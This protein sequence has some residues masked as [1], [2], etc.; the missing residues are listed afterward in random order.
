ML[1]Q[2]SSPLTRGKLGLDR[3][4]RNQR[5]LI[6][7][8]AGKTRGTGESRPSEGAHPR[9]RGENI[10]ADPIGAV[11]NGSSP[12]TRGKLDHASR[13]GRGQGL[14][15]A[16]AGKTTGKPDLGPGS[17]AHPRSRGE[18][19]MTRFK[20][21]DRHGSSP[22]TRGKR[23]PPQGHGEA[24]RLIPAHAGKTGYSRR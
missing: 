14:I 15:P 23:I 1:C 4:L 8:H 17:T 3:G 2:G 21:S 16:H 11:A 6:P 12:L 19:L 13:H 10:I 9:S 22:L 20:H 18:N 7:A 24:E 5:G